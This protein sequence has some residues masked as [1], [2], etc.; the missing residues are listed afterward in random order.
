MKASMLIASSIVCALLAGTALA[1]PGHKPGDGHSHAEEAPYGRPGDPKK[2]ARVV[3]VVFREQDGKMLFLPDRLRFKRGE[4]V[5]F[6]LRNTGAIDHEFVVGTLEENLAHMKEMEK[7]PDMEH[8]DPNALRLK[9]GATG[10][11]L[12]Q[13]TKA[14]TFDFSCLIPGHREAGMF[15]AIVVE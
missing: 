7:N 12:W 15:G 1:S 5:R 8:D 11:I 13:F 6:Q 9:P 3:Q 2:P 4:Q 10:Q 14:G